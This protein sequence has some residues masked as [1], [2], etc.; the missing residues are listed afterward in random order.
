[1]H[2]RDSTLGLFCTGPNKTQGLFSCNV[3][4]HIQYLKQDHVKSH[5]I[6]T[7]ANPELSQGLLPYVRRASVP[8]K[9]PKRLQ[10]ESFIYI[11]ILLATLFFVGQMFD[12]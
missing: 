7:H 8:N 2:L 1:M 10:L 9:I 4:M 5:V 6:R 11:K 3:K 12:I